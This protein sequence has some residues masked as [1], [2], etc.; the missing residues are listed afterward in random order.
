M[1]GGGGG[2]KNNSIKE[3]EATS[4]LIGYAELPQDTLPP[5]KME[6]EVGF[7]HARDLSGQG[8]FL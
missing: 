5:A 4:S 8:G 7:L 6:G 3:K 2:K 1:G